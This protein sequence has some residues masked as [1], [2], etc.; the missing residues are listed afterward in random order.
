VRCDFVSPDGP[1]DGY[2][3]LL[4]P[5]LYLLSAEHAAALAA[6]VEAGGTVLVSYFSGIVDPD[7]HIL[8][9]GYPGALRELLGIRIEEFFPLL[10]GESVALSDY[11]SGVVWSEL[12]RTEGAEQL[13]GY[14]EGPV[15]GSPAISSWPCCWNEF[16]PRPGWRRWS[17]ACRPGSRWCADVPPKPATPSCSTTPANRLRWSYPVLN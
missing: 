15:A 13:A 1:N 12:G 9:G 17:R 7:D 6:F 10:Q 3:V 8:L 4:V 11:G 2:R 5:Q 16:S 14:A